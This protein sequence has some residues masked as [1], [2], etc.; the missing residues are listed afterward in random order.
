[1]SALSKPAATLFI[2]LIRKGIESWIEAGEIAARE[3]DAD[4]EW[5]DKVCEG[6]KWITPERVKR[7][8]DFG[9]K[10]IHPLLFVSG[11]PG[12]TKMLKLPYSLQEKY[13]KE[14]VEVLT[15]NGEVLLVD[16]MNLKPEQVHQVIGPDRIRTIAE[17]RAWLEEEKRKAAEAKP[18]QVDM[19]YRVVN[20][21][22]KRGVEVG[23]YFLSASEMAR[24]LVDLES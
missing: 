7:F 23:G 4:P 8:A 18:V 21:G 17:Q 11:A 20:R 22:N 24:I 13:T 16:V 19:P 15:A 1:M 14:P 12:A 6:C 10:K 5:A 2:E 9:R 3:L